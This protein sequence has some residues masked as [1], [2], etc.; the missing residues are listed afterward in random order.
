[1]ELREIEIFL[2]L[3]EEL[4][5]GRTA[6]RLYLSQ[7]RVSQTIRALE[8]SVGGRLDAGDDDQTCRQ[9]LAERGVAGEIVC[10]RLLRR[11]GRSW[12]RVA[13]RAAGPPWPGSPCGLADGRSGSDREAVRWVHQVPFSYSE[14]NR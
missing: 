10:G 11:P 1:V 12:S 6:E 8:A 3:A 7:A 5:F 13:A 4:H 14:A 9:V 2:V